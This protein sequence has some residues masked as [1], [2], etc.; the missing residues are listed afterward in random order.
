MASLIF[1]FDPV[2]PTGMKINNESPQK[3]S[4]QKINK[5]IIAAAFDLY[6]AC[7]SILVTCEDMELDDIGALR[8]VRRALSRAEGKIIRKMRR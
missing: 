4:E 7:W 5:Q 8:H 3:K 6:G 2:M 1:I